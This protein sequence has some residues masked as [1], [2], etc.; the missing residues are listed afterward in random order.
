M[1]Y[2][3]RSDKEVSVGSSIPDGSVCPREKLYPPELLPCDISLCTWLCFFV[4][5][6][7]LVIAAIIG[8][9]TGVRA[10]LVGVMRRY[11]VI[12]LL[13]I[14]SGIIVSCYRQVTDVPEW[15]RPYEAQ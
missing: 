10:G 6:F 1:G 13:S 11:V 5:V 15:A 2:A 14:I 9:G 12:I 8:R 3:N 4:P 7:G